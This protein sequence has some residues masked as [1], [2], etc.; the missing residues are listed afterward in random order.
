MGYTHYWKVIKPLSE[1]AYEAFIMDI[2]EVGFHQA[3]FI[4]NTLDKTE[5]D[6]AIYFNGIGPESHET[7]VWENKVIDFNFCKTARKNYD[8]AVC[9]V[10]I[11]VKKHYGEGV[12][13][14]SDGNWSEWKLGRNIIDDIFGTPYGEHMGEFIFAKE[15]QPA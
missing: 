5:K 8:P 4:D 2:A 7:F 3:K 11:L 9:A 6:D 10:L 13:I 15:G 12:E 1:E 14:S